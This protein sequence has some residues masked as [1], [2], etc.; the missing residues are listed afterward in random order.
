MSVQ[1]RKKTATRNH[2]QAVAFYDLDGTLSDLNLVHSTL[3]FLANVAEWTGRVTYL[4]RFAARLPKLYLAEQRDRRL[5]NTTMFST[6]EGISQDRLKMLGDLYCE[7]ILAPRLYPQAIEIIE[8]NRAAGLEPVL[9]TGS[10]DF[11]VEPLARLLE[12]KTFAANRLVFSG[13]LATG[14]LHEPVLGGEEKAAWCTEFAAE[15]GLDLSECWG[16]T[17][18]HHD[19]PFL[20]AVGHPV[21]VN[22]DRKLQMTAQTRQWPIVHFV[23]GKRE[24]SPDA[25]S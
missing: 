7:R 11:L 21:A 9:V 19:L 23:R 24:P 2:A 25:R 14:R 18:S 12:I 3:Y 22:P 5:L 17:D 6:F 15:K 10:P 20:A 8:G 1:P 16:Y 4:L 13:G